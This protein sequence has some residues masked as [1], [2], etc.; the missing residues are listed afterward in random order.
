LKNEIPKTRNVSEV[1]KKVL[2]EKRFIE[3]AMGLMI[4]YVYY[5]LRGGDGY[6]EFPAPALER[7]AG[8]NKNGSG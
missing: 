2:K 5:N 1:V 7:K 4:Y 6:A 3:T 8:K